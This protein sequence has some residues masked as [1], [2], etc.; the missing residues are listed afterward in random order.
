MTKKSPEALD[1]KARDCQLEGRVTVLAC[2][3]DVP[4][5]MQTALQ[6]D[7]HLQRTAEL[8]DQQLQERSADVVLLPEL[9]SVSYTR[10]CFSN[11][12]IFAERPGGISFDY[13][14]PVAKKHG[15]SLLYGAP[16]IVTMATIEK[17]AH[18]PENPTSLTICQFI[19]DANGQPAGTF[20]KL[21][22]AQYGASMEK[23]YFERGKGLNH[24]D[25][26]GM[27][28]APQICYDMRFADFAK[29]Q[30]VQHKVQAVLHCVA[31]YRDESFYSWPAFVIAR[32]ME[33][34][35]Y[36]L[37]LNR[38]GENFGGSVFCTPWVDEDTPVQVLGTAEQCLYIELQQA[39]IDRVRSDYTFT[40]DRLADYSAL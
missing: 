11:P 25:V 38:A 20:D 40:S 29:T 24:F 26:N 22:L 7:Q 10:H 35:I 17:S 30:A 5:N 6:R 14:A 19:I 34:Q 13:L 39:E 9:S 27:R 8:I 28:L 33:N 36:W 16:R 31:F 23:D 3:L 18:E 15:A 2:Q 32:A 4:A 37:S 1:E 12:Q 21:H